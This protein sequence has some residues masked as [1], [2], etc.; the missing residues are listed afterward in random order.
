MKNTK[1]RIVSLLLVAIMVATLCPVVF[2]AAETTGYRHFSSIV[3]LGDS[4][5]MGYGLNGYK[6]NPQY[7]AL[8]DKD[9]SLHY[10][11]SQYLLGGVEGSF[12]QVVA[13]TLGV[14]AANC[15]NISYPAFRSKDMFYF[16]GGNVDMSND[17]YFK[18][19][20]TVRFKPAV[21]DSWRDKNGKKT[22]F[23]P[24]EKTMGQGYGIDVG[25]YFINK[26]KTGDK[27]QLV[28]LYAGAAD[29]MF[30]SLQ[31]MIGLIDKENIVGSV[32]KIVKMLG[33]NY[34]SFKTYVPKL[35]ERI[36]E[37]NPDCTIALLGTFNPTKN[38]SISDDVYLPLF[39]SMAS[40]T[41]KMNC[42]YAK[43]AKATDNCVYVDIANV[44]TST[45]DKKIT[46][47]SLINALQ[48][49]DAADFYV[50]D[51]YHATPAGY[52][53]IA[54]Q[55]T[56]QFANDAKRP[57][58]NIVV[59][60][61]SLD[62]VESVKLDGKCVRY[63]FNRSNQKLTVPCWRINAKTLTITGEKNGQS[64]ACVYKLDWSLCGGYTALQVYAT[65][66]SKI[67]CTAK[68]LSAVSHLKT[69]FA[70]PLFH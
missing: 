52:R 66:D 49:I 27:D 60:M 39:N 45:L 42:C 12:P 46:V 38:L 34:A 2:A 59:D 9:T 65:N 62:L 20:Y 69:V 57:C 5:A 13:E 64:I 28:I 61:G 35:M 70:R 37:L 23:V 43:W 47:E 1:K 14:D 6:G 63:S 11:D 67:I 16:L 54:R 53:Y 15:T 22:A 25:D 4:N 29:V 32:A 30:A 55:I 50:E 68:V 26:L 7:A 41:E 24:S 33:D 40:V 36:R 3:T 17:S 21:I 18:A 48:D 8:H 31:Q 56:D 51:I 58:A 10:T 44:E 19:S